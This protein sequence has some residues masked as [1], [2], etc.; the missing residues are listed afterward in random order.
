[1]PPAAVVGPDPNPK[2]RS[3]VNVSHACSGGF[4]LHAAEEPV[5]EVIE[6]L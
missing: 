3:D 2:N 5:R 1:M 4:P 6:G